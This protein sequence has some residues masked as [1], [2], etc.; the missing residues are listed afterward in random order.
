MVVLRMGFAD[1]FVDPVNILAQVLRHAAR[2]ESVSD[3][4]VNGR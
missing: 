1:S 2:L 4:R 3:Q